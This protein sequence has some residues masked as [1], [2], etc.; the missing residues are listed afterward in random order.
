MKKKR[1]V[2]MAASVRARLLERARS[3][4]RPFDELLQYFAMERF[5]YRLSRSAYADR[6]V[7]KGALML[8]FWG[9]PLS[10]STRD[11]DLL[12]RTTTSV[13][14]LVEIVRHVLA[15]EVEDDG[16]RF[17]PDRVTGEAIRLD[18][19]YDGV[20]VRCRAR[21]GTARIALQVDVGFGD[22]VTPGV[23][24]VRYP[25]LLDFEAPRLLGY[26]PE[27]TVAEKFQAM[28]VLDMAN[29]RMKDFFDIW[30][31]ARGQ[32]FRGQVLAEAVEATFRRRRTPLPESVP[33]ALT[34]AFH[35]EPAKRAQWRAY[36]RKARVD[37]PVPPLDEVTGLIA[38][39]LMP[40]VEALRQGMPFERR[41]QPGG[42]WEAL[43]PTDE[44]DDRRDA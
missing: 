30:L 39:F 17:D 3:E 41:W 15:V 35:T 43:A 21:L 13:E 7:L 19:H 14:E 27:S 1:I 25:S 16:L 22:V 9:G 28:V 5:L 12:G 18:A 26:T 20:R 31:L 6:F 40:V 2:N 29:T 37:G 38:A 32:S 10:R 11:I 4:G 23:Q 36:A 33:V 8:Q 34:P 42:P 44:G 24:P